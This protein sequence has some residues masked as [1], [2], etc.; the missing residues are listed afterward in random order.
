M[1]GITLS[2]DMVTIHHK[3]LATVFLK[4][5]LFDLHLQPPLQHNRRTLSVLYFSQSNQT[6]FSSVKEMMLSAN[7]SYTLVAVFWLNNA[8]ALFF[9]RWPLHCIDTKA[10]F[11][12]PTN[13]VSM[14]KSFLLWVVSLTE[15]AKFLIPDPNW[16]IIL[17]GRLVAKWRHAAQ[18]CHWHDQSQTRNAN[19]SKF[20]SLRVYHLQKAN[21]MVLP[22]CRTKNNALVGWISLLHLGQLSLLHRDA[23][24]H[25]GRNKSIHY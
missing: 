12:I 1:T 21:T 16:W 17:F 20:S 24:H 11:F 19:L 3:F 4:P 18:W 8:Q 10:S 5:H 13:L 22:C 14:R 15:A 7:Q 25:L 9:D 6:V 23:A 2:A